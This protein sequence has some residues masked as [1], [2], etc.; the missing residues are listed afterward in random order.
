[1]DAK[2]YAEQES[3]GFQT[4]P[5]I[6]AQNLALYCLRI[7]SAAVRIDSA[8]VRIESASV[9]LDS[10][11]MRIDSAPVRIERRDGHSEIPVKCS[12]RF[13]RSAPAERGP[14]WYAS[15]YTY[16]TDT[17]SAAH[18]VEKAERNLSR[19]ACRSDTFTKT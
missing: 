5:S 15:D 1:M 13:L 14:S 6:F 9:R 11:L 16:S 4:I 19:S 18:A 10:A 17:A 8:S 7:E 2:S 3:E 12:S